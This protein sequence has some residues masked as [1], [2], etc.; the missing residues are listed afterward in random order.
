MVDVSA[1]DET[2]R[3]AVA[4]ADVRLS[5]AAI[6]AIRARTV[7]KGDPLE[8]ARVAGIMA[9][10]KTADL[11]PLCHSVALTHVDITLEARATGYRIVSRASTLGRTGV[12][13]EALVGASTAALTLYDILKA[14][15]RAIII[16]PIQLQEKRGGKSGDFRRGRS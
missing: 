1:K 8:I 16:G 14:I 15:D 9:A 2:E 13:M 7:K 3:E 6:A 11:I 12:E 4:T 5:R 10:K